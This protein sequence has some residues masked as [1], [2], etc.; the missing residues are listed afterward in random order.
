MPPATYDHSRRRV[1]NATRQSLYRKVREC[2]PAIS[3]GIGV[4]PERQILSSINGMANSPNSPDSPSS[5]ALE[6]KK[7]I[8]PEGRISFLLPL[9]DELRTYCFE[10]AIEEIPSL[11]T[12]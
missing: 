5:P 6:M 8:Q 2:W 3:H 4:R 7:E 1:L 11:L 10:H 12:V 9:L